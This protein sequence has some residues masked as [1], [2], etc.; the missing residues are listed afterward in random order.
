MTPGSASESAP[1][2]DERLRRVAAHAAVG[3]FETDARGAVTF[4]TSKWRE[5]TGL[6]GE[7]AFGH[8]WLQ[9]VH[10][11]DVAR[12]ENAW[13][14]AVAGS[15]PLDIRYR[16]GGT[17]DVF[18]LRTLLQP[19]TDASGKIE[20]FAGTTLVAAPITD[21]IAEAIPQFVWIASADGTIEYFNQAWID[22]T[23]LSVEQMKRTG[24][25]GVI[26]PED[27]ALAS[28]RWGNAILTGN[29]YEMEYRLR[30]VTDGTYRWFLARA[31]PVYG[32]DGRATHWVGTAT[33]ID[34]QQRANANLRF[35]LEAGT[36]LSQTFDVDA[37]CSRLASLAVHR[38][39][40]LCLIV[41]SQSHRTHT[42]A[43]IAHRDPSRMR[44]LEHFRSRNPVRF[45]RAIETAIRRNVPLLVTSLSSEELDSAVYEAEH[46]EALASLQIQS[47]MIV[48]LSTNGATYGAITFASSQSGHTFTHEDLEVAEMVAQRAASA[49][50]TA[51]AFDEVRRRSDQLRFIADA[52]EIIF[53]SLDL[54]NIFD[55]L[56]TYIVKDMADLAF[57]MLVENHD[58]L[59]TVSTSHR[60]PRKRR[61]AERFRGQRILRPESEE[62]ALR[63]LASHRATLHATVPSDA[64]LA[65]TWDYL[66]PDL[67]ALDIRSAVTIPLHSRGETF[68]A[69]VAYR[70][71]KAPGPFEERDLAVFEDVGRRLSI[72]IDHSGT[73]ERERRI[74]EALQQTLLPQPALMPNGSGMKFA[75]EYRP[76]S[77]EAD[78]GGDWYDAFR[79]ED[80]T[81][82]VSV[83][84]VT[85]R[86]LTAAGL[87]GKLRQAM[88]IAIVYE[89][90]PARALDAV[91]FQLRTRGSAAIATAFIG[92]I[93]PKAGTMRYASAGHPPPLLRRQSDLVE[94]HASGL[95]LGLRDLDREESRIVSLDGAQLLLLYTD[96]LTEATRDVTFGERRLQQVASSDAILFVHSAAQF[97]C[98]ACLPLDAQDD[99]AVLTVSFGKR[100]HWAFDA[101]NA[102][103]A[104][105]A[106]AQFIAELRAHSQRGSDVDAA[107][108]IFGELVGNVVRHAPGP[109]DVQIEW[110]GEFP[111]LHVT[112]RGKGFIRNPALPIDPL[113]E[114]G[115]GLYIISLLARNVRVE[116]IAGYG[117]HIA[118]EL[119]VRALTQH[120]QTGEPG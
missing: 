17:N 3:L 39:A 26:H 81:I 89:A 113:S 94:L 46:A 57:I 28:E 10:A 4:V 51:N 30:R 59:R 86:G 7:D 83:G 37:I 61:I 15:G 98:D 78:V 12:V 91:D 43:A 90:D 23:G 74:A 45:G 55:R 20:R 87:M 108:L 14:E 70:C 101:E 110:T 96:G 40:D 92:I 75:A 8:G 115:R 19:V 73:L 68:G 103:A 100:A 64:L 25:E 71:G 72:A 88:A 53:E 24:V 107:E 21:E 50:Q 18:F 106:R 80:G 117:N 38:V 2:D 119:P 27:L 22:Y 62:N 56:T 79:L 58:A 84:D 44:A 54:P 13:N 6:R 65:N 41:L 77:R 102:Q 48:P 111:V 16:S 66:A 118:V 76:S 31:T 33:D 114:S 63:M 82:A 120:Q 1:L 85:G 36:A 49:I 47:A 67:R 35:V 109:I 99:T 105:D 97:L 34:T 29:P 95:P 60:N 42:I 116:R 69:L 32:E 9:S 11:Q 93:D 5:I 112:D 104:H 52:S